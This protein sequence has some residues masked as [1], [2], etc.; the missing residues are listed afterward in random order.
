[1]DIEGSIERDVQTSPE[2]GPHDLLM[3]S[4]I[5]DFPGNVPVLAGPDQGRSYR[6]K[7]DEK[8]LQRAPY[9]LNTSLWMQRSDL[10]IMES[11][12]LRNKVLLFHCYAAFALLRRTKFYALIDSNL[13][14]ATLYSPL[15]SLYNTHGTKNMAYDPCPL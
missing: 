3:S 8:F 11:I 9:H 15:A 13:S 6:W 10:Q 7:A 12:P 2:P 1:E 14:Q 5:V 4:G